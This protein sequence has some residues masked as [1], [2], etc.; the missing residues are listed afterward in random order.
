MEYQQ[1]EKQADLAF[2]RQRQLAEEQ[3][4]REVTTSM[5]RE[6]SEKIDAELLNTQ[7]ILLAASGM[8]FAYDMAAIS[9]EPLSRDQREERIQRLMRIHGVP[10]D[11]DQTNGFRPP[12]FASLDQLEDL[13]LR[14]LVE[15]LRHR[16]SDVYENLLT[17][18]DYPLALLD[19]L[20]E[21][22][23]KL[24]ELKRDIDF[25][26]RHLLRRGLPL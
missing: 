4:A 26:R 2:G 22:H 11:D 9:K 23:S 24:F 17:F 10:K 19:D 25:R 16:I 3:H 12:S 20:E 1:A 7:S 15:E 18:A 13:E 14:E 6:L 8:R 21:R 5:S